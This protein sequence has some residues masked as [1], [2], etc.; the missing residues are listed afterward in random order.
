MKKLVNGLLLTTAVLACGVTTT[1][2]ADGEKTVPV[3]ILGVN[4]FHGALSTTGSF[5]GPNGKISGAG[6]AALLAGQLN[7]MQNDFVTAHPTGQTLRVSAGD[8]VGASPANSGLLQDEPTIKAFNAMDFTVGTIGNHE[9]DEGLAEFNRILLGKAPASDSNFLDI[10]KTYPREASKM[11]LVVANVVDASGKIPFGWKPYTVKTLSD[12]QGNEVKVGFIGI[13]TTEI[14]DLVLK[15]NWQDYKFLNE[16]ATI[17]KYETELRQNQKVNAIVV[18]AH[19]PSVQDGDTTTGGVANMLADLEKIDPDHSVDAVFAGHNH[20]YTNGVNG[21]TRVV[22]STSQGKGVAQIT[23][24]IDVE[25]K[26]F[27]KVPDGDVQP[28]IASNGIT[29]DETVAAIVKDADE[30]I[31]DEQNRVIGHTEVKGAISR[32]VA[33][34]APRESVLGNLITDGQRVMAKEAGQEVDFAMTNNGGIRADLLVKDNGD[35]TWGAAQAVQP[36]GNILQVVEMTGS[37]IKTVLEEQYDDAKYFLQVS[38]LSYTFYANPDASSAQKFLVDKI[39]KEDGTPVE[40]DKT[41]KVVINDFLYGGGDGFKGFTKANLVGAI[42][43]DTETFVKY[44]EKASKDGNLTVPE[45][46]RKVKV[47]GPAKDEPTTPTDPSEPNNPSEPTTPTEEVAPLYRLYNPNSGE[48]FFTLNVGEKTHL[49]KLGWHDEKV[50]WNVPTKGDEVYRLYN[51]NAGDHHYTVSAFERDSL[52]KLGWKAEGVAWHSATKEDGKAVYRLYNRNAKAAGA[53]HF[54]IN[55]SEY[56][57]LQNLGWTAEN[58]A[59]YAAK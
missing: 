26:D 6:G 15:K 51:P 47:D 16:A 7:K 42:D 11:D 10:V 44:I 29:P 58:T 25:T 33:K 31:A 41:Y 37:Q 56:D 30:R 52:V 21:K 48:H 34:E 1:I 43:P 4:D 28:V 9:F 18:L 13:V 22:Q 38:G 32:E 46:G 17:K 23:G 27:V 14:P 49:V 35:I 20:V 59:F 2:F 40:M 55:Q 57:Y 45:V 54:T 19:V 8:M 12:G 50:A 24:E 3:Q 36:F 53:H 39:T 5:Y